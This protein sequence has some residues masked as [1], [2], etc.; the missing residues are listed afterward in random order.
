MSN[1]VHDLVVAAML[2]S[3]RNLDAIVGKADFPGG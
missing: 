2:R 1:S 3:P